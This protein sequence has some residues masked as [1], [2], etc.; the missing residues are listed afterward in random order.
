MPIA[1]LPKNL[2]KCFNP[3]FKI[4]PRP[5]EWSTYQQER[6]NMTLPAYMIGWIAD[7]PD[8]HNFIGTWFTTAGSNAYR[9]GDSFL[10]VITT[11]MEQF[12][13]LSIDEY[14]KKAAF[15]RNQN[16]RQE[17]YEN[18]EQY[19]YDHTLVFPLY[20]PLSLRVYRKE[21]QGWY[22]NPMMPDDDYYSYS[23]NY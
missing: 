9:K 3:K 20:Q 22:W 11:P 8:P 2:M 19:S 21:V 6:R 1:E 7:Y 5:V 16:V 4:E 23:L 10:K 13:G 15:E 14:V 12:D 18:V 17:M